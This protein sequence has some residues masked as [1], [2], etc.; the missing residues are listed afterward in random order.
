M[1]FSLGMPSD[2]KGRFSSSFA[3]LA[4]IF[5]IVVLNPSQVPYSEHF[6][7]KLSLCSGYTALKLTQEGDLDYLFQQDW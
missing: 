5:L 4:N 6:A 2:R 7:K 3:S 1:D